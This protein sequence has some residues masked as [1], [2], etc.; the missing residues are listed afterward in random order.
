MLHRQG[1]RRWVVWEE[2]Q[3]SSI[4]LLKLRVA[5]PDRPRPHGGADLD[6]EDGVGFGFSPRLII[7]D[8]DGLQRLCHSFGL[9][10]KVGVRWTLLL[11]GGG[12]CNEGVLT[13]AVL[14]GLLQGSA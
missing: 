1:R 3:E 14:C 13:Q 8:I 6:T 5:F 11:R 10:G 12:G 9:G 2:F 7:A 4:E